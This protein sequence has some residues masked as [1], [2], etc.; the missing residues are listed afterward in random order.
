[1]NKKINEIS[2][3]YG[4]H[5]MRMAIDNVIGVGVNNLKDVNADEVCAQILR[6]TPDNYIMTPEFRA[7]LMRCSIELAQIPIGDILKYIQTNMAYDGVT[8][9][10]GVIVC[11]RQN[12]TNKQ[13]LTCIVPPDTEEE[14]LDEV[15][16]EVEDTNKPIVLCEYQPSRSGENARS[17][18]SGFK[19][20]LHTDGYAGYDRLRKQA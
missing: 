14:T 20:Y 3:K 12:A 1:M 15:A 8:V 9:H 13:L 4:E 17:F 16:K 10:P 19:G 6:D 7:E 2:K 5:M 11:F 18:L